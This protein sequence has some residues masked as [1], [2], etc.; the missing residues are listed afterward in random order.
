MRLGLFVLLTVSA[1]STLGCDES[2]K[3]AGTAR[4][5]AAVP[6]V[7]AAPSAAV[8]KPWFE[9]S[10]SASF[11]VVTL[12]RHMKIDKKTK[13]MGV[14]W[15]APD[16][17]ATATDSGAAGQ[18][19]ELSLTIDGRGQ[20]SGSATGALG[21]LRAV[22]EVDDKILSVRLLSDEEDAGS[23]T[24][25]VLRAEY[26][27]ESFQGTLRASTGD[28]RVAHTADLQLTLGEPGASGEKP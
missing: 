9:G 1:S 23:V 10:W 8:E 21:P 13:K 20:V 25:A 2:G 28:S 12:S 15:E 26:K 17:G 7:S 5:S 22:G 27:G 18:K 16:G 19:M 11:D 3:D 24:S 4:A 6:L 14:T